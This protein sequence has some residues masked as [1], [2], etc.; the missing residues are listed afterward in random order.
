MVLF[1]NQINTV[2][3]NIFSIFI[4]M[5]CIS[6]S[7]ISDAQKVDTTATYSIS[8]YV[9][10][11]YAHYTDSV[12]IGNFQKFPTVSPR[13]NSFGLNT[14]QFTGHYDGERIRAITT[15]QFGDIAQSAWSKTYNF[16]QEAHAGVRICKMLWLDAGFFRTHFGTEFLLPIENITSSVSI[17]TFYEPYYESGLRLNFDPTKQLEINLFLLNGY[18]IFEDN[19]NKKSFGAG[20]TYAFS[21]GIG[22]GYTNYLGDD[23]PPGDSLSHL[24]FDQNAF[25]N[26]QHRKITIQAGGDFGIQRNSDIVIPHKTASMYSGLTTIKYQFIKWLAVYGRGEIFHDPNGFM[27]TIIADQTGK[28]TGYKLWGVTAGIEYKPTG[29]SYIRLEGRR[30]QM[31]QDQN[32]FHYNGQ[33]R[34]YRWEILFNIGLSFDLIKGTETKINS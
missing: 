2:K 12:G 23:S 16:I 9:D 32:I 13:S 3:K 26:Y 4:L 33:D 14:M 30:L 34:N 15:F 7:L 5:H 27:S 29:N 24:R 17:G 1:V 28:L 8:A 6:F 11:Y 20:V 10:G 25:I 18:G 22:I 31:D 21:N 19:N